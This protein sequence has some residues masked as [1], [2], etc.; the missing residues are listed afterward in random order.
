MLRSLPI[1]RRTRPPILALLT[2]ALLVPALL[3]ATASAQSLPPAAPT[4]LAQQPTPAAQSPV[5]TPAP[6]P[7][8]RAQVELSQ[9]GLSV[10]AENSSL[11]QILRDIS[12]VTGMKVTGGV[13]DERVFGTYGP[14]PAQDVLSQLLDG[15][16]SNVLLK[17]DA[18]HSVTELVLTPRLGGVTPPNPNAARDNAREETDLPPQFGGR[19][20]GNVEHRTSEPG[21]TQPALQPDA[22][23]VVEPQPTSSPTSTPSDPGTTT[24]QSPNG[25]KTPQEIYEDLMRKQQQQQQQQATP[26][27]Q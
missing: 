8:Y 13:A 4:Q 21:R 16:G 18:S 10:I 7:T 20:R 6:A 2:P 15:T 24:Q 27:P 14:G 11:N 3:C 9:G 25:V 12:Q 26:P 22:Q 17:Q 5:Q 19:R 23:P 1:R